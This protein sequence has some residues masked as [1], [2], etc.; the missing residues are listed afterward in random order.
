V[1]I[2][3]LKS[4]SIARENKDLRPI[5][6]LS[7]A[8]TE[9]EISGHS[10]QLPFSLKLFPIALRIAAHGKGNDHDS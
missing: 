1:A 7:W 4:K 2:V 8:E 9:T 5:G 6:L 10:A 3:I